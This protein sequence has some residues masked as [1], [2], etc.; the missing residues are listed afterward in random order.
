MFGGVGPFHDL[1]VDLAADLLETLLELRALVTAIGIEFDQERMKP[2]HQA[3]QKDTAIAVLNIGG[4]N[5]REQQQALRVYKDMAFLTF[6]FLP[7]IIA[8]WVD[9]GPPFSALLTL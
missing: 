4:V 7:R 2:E 6:D 1:D 3:H 9:R 8:W 5:E